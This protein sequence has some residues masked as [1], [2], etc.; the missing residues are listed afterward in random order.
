MCFEILDRVK[1]DTL[2]AASTGD[3]GKNGLKA[4]HFPWISLRN[5]L[6]SMDVL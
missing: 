1:I 4:V 6:C 2:W 5:S 3:G